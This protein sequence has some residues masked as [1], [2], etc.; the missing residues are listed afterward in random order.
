M[1][2]RL[3]EK[4]PMIDNV[5]AFVFEPEEPQE[6]T[7]GQ[8]VRVQLDHDNPDD[9][10]PKRFFTNWAPPYEGVVQITTRLTGS[11][12]KQALASLDVGDDSLQ[13]IK[14]HEGDFV[15]QDSDKSLSFVAAGTGVT[16]YYSILFQRVQEGE[17]FPATLVYVGRN[18]LLPWRNEF[19]A[20]EE[21]N[22]EFTVVYQIGEQFTPENLHQRFPELNQSLVYLSGPEPMVEDVGES[23]KQAGLL[24]E[25]LMQ[26]WFPNYS[27]QD[28]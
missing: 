21:S 4:Q 26:D 13:L 8:Y 7:A 25:Q 14:P 5:W 1:K 17:P 11:T 3:V 24:E 15:W 18:E 12:F 23:L 2:L 20:L 9:E 16:P 27:N 19:A 6:Y 10:G 22:P 28:Y